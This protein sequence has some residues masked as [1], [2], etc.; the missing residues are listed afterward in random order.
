MNMDDECCVFNLWN[1]F[2]RRLTKNGE[3]FSGREGGLVPAL[4]QYSTFNETQ[5][6]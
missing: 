3:Y 2:H 4:K 1:D 6:Y 5:K